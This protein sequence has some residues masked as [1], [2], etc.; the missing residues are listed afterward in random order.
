MVKNLP[1]NVG[2]I[3]DAGLIPGLERFPGGGKGN[4]LENCLEN[5]MNREACWATV[6]RVT[7]SQ[8][9]LKQHLT[10]GAAGGEIEELL[11][12][13][14]RVSVGKGGKFWR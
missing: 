1:A 5:P 10:T 9:R 12:N 3:R 4:P 7:L 11:F 8:P 14:H 2:D 6:H 13:E